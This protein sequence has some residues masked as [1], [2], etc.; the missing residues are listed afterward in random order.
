[1]KR[2][3]LCRSL[4]WTLVSGCFLALNAAGQIVPTG[5]P[6]PADRDVIQQAID[7]AGAN[8]IVVLKG[9]FIFKDDDG[10]QIIQPNV[11]LKGFVDVN[12][13]A[14]AAIT[15]GGK[16]NA[17]AGVWYVIGVEN[18]GARIRYITLKDFKAVGILVMTPSSTPNTN[19]V[20][21][22]DNG[23][24]TSRINGSSHLGSCGT[25]MANTDC[26]VE[27]MDNI[28]STA[29]TA[30]YAWTNTGDIIV[31]GNT[32]TGGTGHGCAFFA[33]SGDITVSGNTAAGVRGI[34]V[35]GSD[36]Q[37]TVTGNTATG[38]W[39][40]L[41]AQYIFGDITVSG[42]TLT[43][44]PNW[45]GALLD[46]ISRECIVTENTIN[47]GYMGPGILLSNTPGD[48]KILISGNN[49]HGAMD[50][51]Y[52]STLGMLS[53]EVPVEISNNLIEPA[54]SNPNGWFSDGICGQGF[55]SPL[56]ILIN[57]IRVIADQEGDNPN[58]PM[59]GIALEA[60]D[61]KANL[62][63]DNPPVS[64]RDNKI[65]IRYPYPETADEGLPSFGIYLG[66][67]GG[68]G[69][70]NVTVEAN[71]ISGVVKDGIDCQMYSRNNL[72]VGNDLSGLKT[73][74]TQITLWG[75][76]TLLQ[77]N[78]LGFANLIPGSSTAIELASMQLEGWPLPH[79]TVNC[80]L[81]KNDY[82][83]TGLPG[84]SGGDNGCIKIFSYADM[85]GLGTEVKD[86]LVFESGGFPK[87]TGGAKQQVFENRTALVY[88]NRI[89]GLP[90]NVVANPGIG[91]R[92][93]EAGGVA[94]EK[95]NALATLYA[96][97][98][99]KKAKI[100]EIDDGLL[101]QVEVT[102]PSQMPDLEQT[103]R[104]VPSQ[105]ELTENYPNPFNP[106]TTIKYGLTKPSHVRIEV[107]NSLGQM[108]ARLV[109]C[110]QPAGNHEVRF[111][112]SGM[113]SGM[114]VYRLQ[115]EGLVQSRTMLLVR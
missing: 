114:Y 90:A 92:L 109:D 35:F 46:N 61:A 75:N 82:R 51:I 52:F 77:D 91:K 28:M 93:K 78:I 57:T 73:W 47:G 17:A 39:F 89:V 79:P 101:E 113:A 53:T 96:A 12:G 63:G 55:K 104:D 32:L 36:G 31:S 44:G 59:Y 115:A 76:N 10:V 105:P 33:N 88:D 80:S 98:S 64:I 7:L 43:A 24:S 4:L 45:A 15:G 107:F 30:V 11:T 20:V 23:I 40:G 1:M 22:E 8:G 74:N 86:N 66:V 106:S 49:I 29:R 95:L 81:I 16:W 37:V 48:R 6:P 100:R 85:G 14:D 99:A 54:F 13:I 97:G 2:H 18:V 62:D 34:S 19:P 84:W 38:T 111:N 94:S 60:W 3:T 108:V 58:C 41:Y 71:R 56:N 72:I 67:I 103:V 42:N 5:N 50:G 87:G 65:E 27:I 69:I 102:A 70:N 25:Y 21:I 110:E 26:P 83:L 9:N 112:A 68:G